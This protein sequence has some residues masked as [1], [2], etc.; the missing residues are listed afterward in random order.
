LKTH[1]GNS[2]PKVEALDITPTLQHRRSQ[3]WVSRRA[4][5]EKSIQWQC[6]TPKR[7]NSWTWMDSLRRL[8]P[9]VKYTVGC[10]TTRRTSEFCGA[11]NSINRFFAKCA[12][13]AEPP[14]EIYPGQ[15]F[16]QRMRNRRLQFESL[17]CWIFF[18][19]SLFPW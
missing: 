17:V 7:R 3:W 16:T 10:M 11:L 13:H 6:G 4:T 15:V 9:R 18:C 5:K 8:E 12:F 1:I 2:N 19:L 14:L